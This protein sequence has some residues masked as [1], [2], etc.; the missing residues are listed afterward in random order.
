VQSI[1]KIS[2]SAIEDLNLEYI[3]E[4]IEK[5]YKNSGVFIVSVP[6]TIKKDI[7]RAIE[8]ALQDDQKAKE[9]FKKIYETFKIKGFYDEKKTLESVNNAL[10]ILELISKIKETYPALEGQI[11]LSVE[12][13]II[14]S[15]KKYLTKKIDSE[16]IKTYNGYESGII[17]DQSRNEIM[18]NASIQRCK[19]FIKNSDPDSITFIGGLTASTS[20]K[21]IVKLQDGGSDLIASFLVI[22]SESNRLDLWTNVKGLMSADPS[23]IKGARKIDILSYSE[24]LE[25]F[26]FIPSIFNP[27]AMELL[28]SK[29]VE[30]YVN[31]IKAPLESGTVIR[32]EGVVSSNVV[33]A[34]VHL[35]NLAI[36]TLMGTGLRSLLPNLL[37]SFLL[38]N[39]KFYTVTQ[40]PS[41][42]E[43]NIIIDR[44]DINSYRNIIEIQF[45]GEK[46]QDYRIVDNVCAVSIIGEGMRGT[47]GVASRLFGAVAKEKINIIMIMQ[48][49]SELNIGFVI[50]SQD[51]RRAINAV[52][53]EFI[54]SA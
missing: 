44:N 25:I 7:K 22:S 15:I 51:C 28:K 21:K 46:I 41:G 16:K 54:N 35:D 19:N 43:V 37:N 30:L 36:F 42:S 23:I 31:D 29:G 48:G 5:R 50:N 14:S 27:E 4:L 6:S 45:M 18:F 32:G 2:G 3:G 24:A 17:V 1:A 10:E 9:Q 11:Y 13:M 47:P 40:S 12:N 8:T 34:V 53:N 26:S 39:L 33:K 20:D 49:S 38:S 52:H